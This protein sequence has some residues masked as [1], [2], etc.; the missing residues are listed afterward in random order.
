MDANPLINNRIIAKYQNY[1]RARPAVIYGCGPSL[2][3][4]DIKKLELTIEPIHIVMKMAILSPNVPQIDYYFFGD[5]NEKSKLYED[6]IK[7]L[8]CPKFGLIYQNGWISDKTYDLEFCNQTKSIPINIS[9]K[10]GFM[11]DVAKHPMYRCSTMFPC[12]QFALFLGC[13]PIYVVG[14]DLS[15]QQSFIEADLPARR[16]DLRQKMPIHLEAF[17]SFKRNK[18]PKVRVIHV[19]P[20][21]IGKIFDKDIHI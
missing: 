14:M 5:K 18:Y 7:D 10:D 13:D 21:K 20:V 19:N 15:N 9:Y 8:P 16:K 4:F 12:L 6:M 11:A 3:R 1:H 17:M 2:N